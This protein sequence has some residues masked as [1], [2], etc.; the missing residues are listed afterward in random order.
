MLTLTQLNTALTNEQIAQARTQGVTEGAEDPAAEEIAGAISKVETYTAGY[1]LPG[2]WATNLA[3]ALAAHNLA[4]RLGKPTEDQVRIFDR[5]NKE[6]E[7]IRDGKFPNLVKDPE[8][9]GS[10]GKVR[11]GSRRNILPESTS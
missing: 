5:A 11:S 3:R 6:L 10:T 4:T 8:G 1:T 2:P 9:I 7:D